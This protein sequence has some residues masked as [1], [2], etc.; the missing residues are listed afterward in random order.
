VV[1]DS[2][3]HTEFDRQDTFCLQTEPGGRIV[4][5][6]FLNQQSDAWEISATV[7]RAPS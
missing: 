6:T 5:M 4:F 2:S 7:W 3:S 1:A